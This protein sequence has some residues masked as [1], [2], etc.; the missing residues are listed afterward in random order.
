MNSEQQQVIYHFLPNIQESI[1]IAKP[2][3]MCF[4]SM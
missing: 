4:L 3:L 2:W 1:N